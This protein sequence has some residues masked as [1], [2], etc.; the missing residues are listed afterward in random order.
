MNKTY[1]VNKNHKFYK[2]GCVA[3]RIGKDKWVLLE[4]YANLSQY[5]VIE[6]MMIMEDL[7]PN[8]KPE[9]YDE[10][11]EKTDEQEKQI[12]CWECNR[13]VNVCG[14]CDE[15]PTVSDDEVEQLL[16][17]MRYAELKDS[18]GKTFSY[19]M[20]DAGEYERQRRRLDNLPS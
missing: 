15:E 1:K 7:S 8:T 10:V 13:L 20:L 11:V 16:N 2:Q 9:W 17:K 4:D 19:Y 5:A 3:E 14:N 12:T 18:D 6:S